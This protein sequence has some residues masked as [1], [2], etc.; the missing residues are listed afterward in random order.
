MYQ[1]ISS[2]HSAE[3][4]SLTVLWYHTVCFNTITATLMCNVFHAVDRHYY[5][6]TIIIY[7]LHR[8]IVKNQTAS[9]NSE[10]VMLSEKQPVCSAVSL[11]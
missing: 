7:L 11:F 2:N 3:S 4:W 1:Q 10:H 8:H 5:F 9:L 6:C